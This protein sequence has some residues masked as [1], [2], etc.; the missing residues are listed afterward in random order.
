MIEMADRPDKLRFGIARQYS[1]EDGFDKLEEYREEIRN[2]ALSKKLE[3]Y[4]A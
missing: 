4:D 1:E 3:P 2:T